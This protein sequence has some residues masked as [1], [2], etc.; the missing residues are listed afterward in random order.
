LWAENV[1]LG[2]EITARGRVEKARMRRATQALLEEFDVAASAGD[3]VRSLPVAVRQLIEIVAALG[4]NTRFLLLDE[5]TT[6]L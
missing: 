6:A 5:P 3:K 2:R 4:R 1:F